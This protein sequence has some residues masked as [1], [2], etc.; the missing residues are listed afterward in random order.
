MSVLAIDAGTTG[1]TALVVTP[2]GRIAARGYQE[3]PQHFPRPGWVEHAPEEIWQAT[4]EAT[5]AA[6]QQ[7]DAADLHAV[8][9]TNQRETVLLWDRETLGAP[10]RAIVWQDRRTAA[11]CERLREEGHEERVTELT[12]LRLDPYFSGTKLAWLRENEP[13]TW[14]LVEE[15]RYA[16]G[17]VDSYLVARMTR[18]TWH[19]TDVSNASRTLLMDLATGEWSDELCE[20]FGVPR[21]ALPE[22]V[23]NWGEI[24]TTDPAAFCGLALPIAGLA[25][26]QQ[27]A[28]FGQTCFDAGDAKCTYG[29]GSFILTN[30][31]TALERSDAGLLT[32]AAWRSPDG[33]LT[34]ALEGAIFV[35]GAAVQWLRDGIQIVGSAAETE[36]VAATVDSSEGVVFVPALTG[37][38]APHWDPHARGTILGI[39]RGTTRAHIVRATLEA[40][41]FE[42][43]DVLATMPESTSAALRVDGG[44]SANDLL[45]S[46]QA[47]QLGVPVERPQIVETTGLG[48]AFLAG[49]GVGVWDSTDQLRETWQLDARFEPA[50]DPETRAAAD[51]TYARWQEGVRR[52][53]AWAD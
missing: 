21:D 50:D 36:A 46:L 44:A 14:A 5:R 20:L 47:D 15:G 49:L 13:R 27:S 8:G 24:G 16:V 40:I 4:L 34:Y 37:L 23:P 7:H 31:G 30:T 19:V 29:T 45:C 10:R 6:L 53:L 52:S 11:I 9:I 51:A 32:T 42:V 22:L 17:T 35:T 2:E 41:T 18:G 25:G 26:D 1:V 3:F 43:R 38:G 39:T 48:A 12:G 28:L 33:E